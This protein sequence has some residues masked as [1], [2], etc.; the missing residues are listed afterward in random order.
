MGP[1]QWLAGVGLLCF[2][3]VSGVSVAAGEIVP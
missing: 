2:H 1:L 3:E